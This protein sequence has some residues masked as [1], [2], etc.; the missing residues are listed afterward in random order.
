[1]NKP[2]ED[3][4]K[5]AEIIEVQTG[6]GA[7]TTIFLHDGTMVMLNA[8]SKIVYPKE[9][10]DHIRNVE[11]FGQAYFEVAK[12]EN[13][14]FYVNTMAVD[15]QVLGTSFGVMAYDNDDVIETTLISGSVKLSWN[16][17]YY[18]SNEEIILSPGYQAV[19]SRSGK[20]ATV[21]MVSTENE[22][23]WREGNLIFEDEP[24]ELI[25]KKV[26]RWCETKIYSEDKRLNQLEFSG[27]FSKGNSP[28]HLIE[29]IGITTP[30]NYT[31][32]GDSIIILRS[33]N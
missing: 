4:H 18:A 3:I 10:E 31:L 25:L 33:K 28:E 14:P 12:E 8:E 23:A 1:L 30:V 20:R 16:N 19:F 6:V 21:N 11:L 24:L 17:N 32:E 22:I 2:T 9:F 5:V 13:R 15:I 7:D 26:N 27:I 29:L